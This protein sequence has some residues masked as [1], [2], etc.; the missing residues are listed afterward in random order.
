VR[1]RERRGETLREVTQDRVSARVRIAIFLSWACVVAAVAIRHEPWRDEV[2]AYT[3]A[4][5]TAT[6]RDLF[7]ALRTDGDGH[8][9]LWYLLLR[10]AHAVAPVPAVLPVVSLLVAAAA[11]LL[12]VVRSPFG[13][14]LTVLFPFSVLPLY[15]Y[16]V[17]ARNY[18]VSL[19]LCFAFAALYG[20]RRRLL[21][22]LCLLLL[23]NTNAHAAFLT[24]ALALVWC[25]D[26]LRRGDGWLRRVPRAMLP[27]AAATLGLLFAAWTA[28]PGPEVTT[29]RGMPAAADSLRMLLFAPSGSVL[30]A[31]FHAP[32]ILDVA[33]FLVLAAGFAARPSRVLAATGATLGLY[34]FFVAVYPGDLR[35]VGLLLV[36]V[37]TLLWIEEERAASSPPPGPSARG[38][39][40]LAF[41]AV[42]PAALG[43]GVVA[44]VAK[45]WTDL[46]EEMSASRAL[47]AFLRSRPDL[48]GAILI[49]EPD[50]ALEPL[51]YYVTN[52]IYL[53]REARYAR[54]VSFTTKNRDTLS[55]GELLDAAERLRRETGRRVLLLL[56]PLF[57][58]PGSRNIWKYSY[59]KKTFTR[60]SEDLE[61]LRREAAP[62]GR[63]ED[64]PQFDERYAV[65]ELRDPPP[66]AAGSA[67]AASRQNR[68]D[69]PQQ[70]PGI[71]AETPVVDVG[72]V[73]AH[74]LVE[75]G[76]LVAS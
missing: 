25:V 66:G 68:G 17:M 36:L 56:Q 7:G 32:A 15:E 38:L 54:W 37:L 33:V 74:P 24:A 22:A 62:I 73:E 48:S 63:F 44:G 30:A 11:V 43:V 71:E 40:R 35:H 58:D 20:S 13:P 75:L 31:P 59:G 51:P 60:S 27:I 9:A 10:G 34:S 69:R 61:R 4:T 57:V 2:R 23:S 42:L 53:P 72:E 16:S 49:G 3:I 64:T 5:S 14:L 50:Y 76:D 41:G 52:P 18:G 21:L 6:L 28:F 47:A 39:F 29:H 45:A 70:D 55:L 12:F 46:R 1:G 19:L 65:F 8:P 26:E 67:R